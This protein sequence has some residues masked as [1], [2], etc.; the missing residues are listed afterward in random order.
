LGWASPP[1]CHQPLLA[2]M[3]CCHCIDPA[4]SRLLSAKTARHHPPPPPPP[5]S[6]PLQRKVAPVSPPQGSTSTASS[7]SPFG[8]PADKGNRVVRDLIVR[9][10]TRAGLKLPQGDP[11]QEKLDDLV[12]LA[13]KVRG[14]GEEEEEGVGGRRRMK[15]MI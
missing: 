14:E 11:T 4:R 6:P 5:F 9:A 8:A 7:P 10:G 12:V 3:G 2:R 13:L 15:M 1:H